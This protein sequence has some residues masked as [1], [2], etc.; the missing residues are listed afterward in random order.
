MTNQT[1]KEPV[2][3]LAKKRREYLLKRGETG[4]KGCGGLVLALSFGSLFLWILLSQFE[5]I[6]SK[7]PWLYPACLIGIP[8]SYYLMSVGIRLR[9]RAADQAQAVTYVPSVRKQLAALPA[10]EILVRGSDQ[11]AATPE[12]LLR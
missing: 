11:P 7:S 12:E 6:T 9:R 5:A 8:I 3:D 10:E 2:K 1:H 4:T